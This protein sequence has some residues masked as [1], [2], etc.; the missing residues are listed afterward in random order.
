MVFTG[1]ITS[2]GVQ[3]HLPLTMNGSA[4]RVCERDGMFSQHLNN[5]GRGQEL[6]VNIAES[7]E[8]TSIIRIKVAAILHPR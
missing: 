4:L 7:F 8:T 2:V 3:L 5:N 1:Q 6:F